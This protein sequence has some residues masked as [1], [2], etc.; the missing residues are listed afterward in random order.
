MRRLYRSLIFGGILA[1]F[2]LS[3][4]APA[5]ASTKGR[6][7][8][9]MV[10]TAATAYSAL[11]KN[12]RAALVGALATAQAWKN[13]EDSRK[14]DSKK[15][16]VQRYSYR[17]AV[18]RTAGSYGKPRTTYYRPRTVSTASYA[19]PAVYRSTRPVSSARHAAASVSSAQVAQ[20]KSKITQLEAQNAELKRQAHINELKA[21]NNVL[22]AELAR[23]REA[24][25]AQRPLVADVHSGI[26]PS[27]VHGGITAMV[28][29]LA[30]GLV[31][32]AGRLSKIGK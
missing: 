11:K 7:N 21:E 30:I 24:A 14:R 18:Y 22:R 25:S 4:I 20:L 10:L 16:A 2:S 1:V 28:A 6:K 26:S 5:F 8:T 12:D 19:R 27:T 13:Y 29:V 17:P 31:F 23:Q 9:A 15:K 3:A 32:G